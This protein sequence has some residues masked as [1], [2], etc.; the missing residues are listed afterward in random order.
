M[1]LDITYG[2]YPSG[3]DLDDTK[4]DTIKDVLSEDTGITTVKDQFSLVI[5]KDISCN[6]VW[7]FLSGTSESSFGTS[8]ISDTS[9]NLNINIGSD[10]PIENGKYTNLGTIKYNDVDASILFTKL[11]RQTFIG[12][13]IPT[14]D[15]NGT[16]AKQ[17]YAKVL[18]IPDSAPVP[19]T[20][21]SGE[22]Y[23]AKTAQ[24]I[25]NCTY[26]G[27]KYE[28]MNDVSDANTIFDVRGDVYTS[29][30][31]G[32]VLKDMSIINPGIAC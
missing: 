16:N 25:N 10:W 17:E 13:G 28:L 27:L 15:L 21:E 20:T 3:G 5:D 31:F 23:F 24:Q 14:N 19:T 6:V 26:P 12:A 11:L 30:V 7:Q 29:N 22:T 4:V 1:G 32:G 8:N 18:N 9:F 2:E